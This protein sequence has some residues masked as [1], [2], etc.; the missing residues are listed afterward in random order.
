MAAA[1][2]AYRRGLQGRD[3]LV[4]YAMKANSSLGVLQWFVEQG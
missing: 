1:L 4:C 3:H 2:G